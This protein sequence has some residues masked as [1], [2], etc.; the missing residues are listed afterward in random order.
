MHSFIN[1]LPNIQE[2]LNPVT[3]PD[4]SEMILYATEF[5]LHYT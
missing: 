3:N 1:M 5:S 4:L 2:S